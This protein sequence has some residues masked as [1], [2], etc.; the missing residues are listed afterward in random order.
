MERVL[1][2]LERAPNGAAPAARVG[3][4]PHTVRVLVARG[5]VV[6]WVAN[7]GARPEH[8]VNDVRYLAIQPAGRAAL[9]EHRAAAVFSGGCAPRV[10][11]AGRPPEN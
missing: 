3:A 6:A 1:G 11:P 10:H 9:V 5:W 2:R 4:R 7:F 8:P